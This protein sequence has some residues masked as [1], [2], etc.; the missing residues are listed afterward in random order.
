ME[1]GVLIT[2]ASRGIG[3]VCALELDRLGCRRFEV[4]AVGHIGVIQ[5][6]LPLLR[7]GPGGIVNIDSRE[8]LMTMHFARPYCSSKFAM[9]A[10]LDT[11]RDSSL[12]RGMGLLKLNTKEVRK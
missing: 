7:K 9:E 11:L 6:F 1:R 3:R 4:H 2:G 10:P 5:S 12:C 8:G